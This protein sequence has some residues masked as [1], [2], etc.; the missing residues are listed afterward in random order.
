MEKER[1]LL[2]TEFFLSMLLQAQIRLHNYT[3]V[4]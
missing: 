1:T 4:I 2:S 3:Y